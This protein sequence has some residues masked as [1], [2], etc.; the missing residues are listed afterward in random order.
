[1]AVFPIEA[2]SFGR[3]NE[4]IWMRVGETRMPFHQD[5]KSLV[6]EEYDSTLAAPSGS[7]PR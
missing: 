7:F 2:I 5:V 3:E 4:R 6:V 1:M